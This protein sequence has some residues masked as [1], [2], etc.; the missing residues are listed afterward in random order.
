MVNRIWQGHFGRGIVATPNDFGTR[1]A[2]PSNQALLD[3]LAVSFQEH[4]W[5]LKW[6]TKQIMMSR[7]Y[8]SGPPMASHPS[9]VPPVTLTGAAMLERFSGS[10]PRS[11]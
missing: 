11:T 8:R 9:Q 4:N 10:T 1:G 3:Y 5:D 2:P 7:V 6:L